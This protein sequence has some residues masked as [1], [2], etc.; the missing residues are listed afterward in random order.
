MFSAGGTASP[1]KH[2]GIIALM[3]DHKYDSIFIVLHFYKHIL[4]RKVL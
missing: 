2:R 1:F 4:F 3:A